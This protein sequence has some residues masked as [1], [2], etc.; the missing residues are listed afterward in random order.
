ML[1]AMASP[2]RPVASSVAATNSAACTFSR[3]SCCRS[4]PGSRQLGFFTNS[5]VR[6]AGIEARGVDVA[7]AR[8]ELHM[9]HDRA[10]LLGKPGHVEHG[11]AFFFEVR[12]HA[13]DLADGDHT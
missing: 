13:D 5:A 7:R 6:A 2:M 12:G 11:H 9:R 1:V 8:R 4:L 3:M 10:V